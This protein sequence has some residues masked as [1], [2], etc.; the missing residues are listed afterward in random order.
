VRALSPMG[1]YPG[2]FIP[3]PH[4]VTRG[5]RESVRR[6]VGPGDLPDIENL[7]HHLLH[8]LLRGPAVPGN[9]LLY[10]GRRVFLVADIAYFQGEDDR[11]NGLGHIHGSGRVVLEK[12]FFEGREF[13]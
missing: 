4:A 11:A 12:K 8:L 7:L 10:L 9:G 13:R 3:Y 2:Q 1:L 6:I 5:H